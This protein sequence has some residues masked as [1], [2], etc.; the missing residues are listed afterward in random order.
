[1]EMDSYLGS[2]TLFAFNWAPKDFALC[3][4]A[5]LPISQMS[6]L[7]SL[8]G[9]NFGGDGR[10][11]FGLPDLRGRVPVGEGQGPGLTPRYLG[12]SFGA[13]TMTNPNQLPAHRH[14]VQEIQA[15]KT[16]TVNA[17]AAQANKGVP[18]SNY[19]AEGFTGTAATKNYADSHDAT[20]ASDAV[21]LNVAN[22]ATGLT[23]GGEP[24]MPPSLV[25]NYC[26]CTQGYFPSRP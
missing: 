21:Q 12:E 20:M 5:L 1:M 15:G 16:V 8:L 2:I 11:T 24:F 10:V 19:W 26:I 3:D 7:Y 17:K 4:G 25:L 14:A 18:T 22:L 23:G 13:E 9:T 6:A